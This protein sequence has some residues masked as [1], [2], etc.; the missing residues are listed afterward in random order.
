MSHRLWLKWVLQALVI[1]LVTSASRPMDVE[2]RQQ[3]VAPAA[4]A[5][6]GPRV[7]VSFSFH[8]SQSS[9]GC[10][11]APFTGCS[12]RTITRAF[13]GS[14]MLGQ[15]PGGFEGDGLGQYSETDDATS[16]GVRG[17]SQGISEH[18]K[19]SGPGNMSARAMFSVANRVTGGIDTSRMSRDVSVVEFM[20]TGD[21]LA[22]SSDSQD[23]DKTEHL[24][25]KTSIGFDCQFYD[26][27]LAHGG[28][29][30]AYKDGDP[31]A[32]T[33]TLDITPNP[34]ELRIYGTVTGL[35]DGPNGAMTPLPKAKVVV[36][37]IRDGRLAPF[38]TSKPDFLAETAT[39]DTGE[40]ELKYAKRAGKLT[41][42]V[43]TPGEIRNFNPLVD[44]SPNPI[45]GG[46]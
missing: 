26:V 4:S 31:Q 22:A 12:T 15:I 23:C 14:A 17:C 13:N 41:N 33:C 24:D 42:L 19:I 5:S 35:F 1:A 2:A 38:S 20:V 40:F 25:W 37:Q 30:T 7:A 44:T 8:V 36:A 9:S 10:A 3:A 46:R 11:P 27:D 18:S 21:D 43:A 32:G 6:A 39:S 16:T 29:Y 45:R 34:I 28:T